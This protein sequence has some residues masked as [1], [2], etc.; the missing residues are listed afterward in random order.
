MEK[1]IIVGLTGGIGSGKSTVARLLEV[2]SIPVFYADHAGIAAYDLAEVRSSVVEL[3]GV[4]AYRP[5]GQPDRP[6]IASEVFANPD[7][8]SRLNAIIHPAVRQKFETWLEAHRNV[9]FVVREA[10]IL[11]ES[12]SHRDCAFT[13]TVEADEAL[14]LKR[15]M[16]RGNQSETE[17]R[18]RMQRQWS[19]EQR[20]ALADFVL[21]NDGR[22]AIIPQTNLILSEIM[23]QRDVQVR[24]H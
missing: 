2:L 22:H 12:G 9:D 3:L 20:E 4:R 16:Q 19:R 24:K 23:T 13:I 15:V 10:A 11:F 17:V 8:L 5:D 7:K 14:R 6:W 18:A 1:P 21:E